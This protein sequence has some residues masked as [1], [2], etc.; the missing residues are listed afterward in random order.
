LALFVEAMTNALSGYGRADD[1]KRWGAGVFLQLIDPERF[2]GRK[3][4]AREMSFLAQ[5]CFEAPVP[6]GK[7]PVRMPGQAALMRREKQLAK[8]VELHP[9]ILPGLTERSE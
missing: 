3:A 5:S 8:G 9:T 7:S 2:G 4:F 6:K 1:V